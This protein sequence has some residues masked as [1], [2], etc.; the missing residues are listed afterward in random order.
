MTIENL[1]VS[2]L[3]IIGTMKKHAKILK[4]PTTDSRLESGA[5]S[6]KYNQG[7]YPLK[8][9]NIYAS[10]RNQLARTIGCKDKTYTLKICKL[11]PKRHSTVISFTYLI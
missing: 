10:F 1:N 6:P 9:N 4:Q 8:D 2:D 11:I 7:F 5:S 3:K